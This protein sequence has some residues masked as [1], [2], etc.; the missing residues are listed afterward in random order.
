MKLFAV[1]RALATVV[2]MLGLAASAASAQDEKTVGLTMA[3]PAAVGLHWQ[4]A[5]RFAIRPDVTYGWSSTETSSSF[6]GGTETVYSGGVS[7]VVFGLPAGQ[8]PV[9]YTS[10][11][12]VRTNNVGAGISGIVTVHRNEAL[13]IYLGPRISY[14]KAT[15]TS[16]N[17]DL[18]AGLPPEFRELVGQQ[19]RTTKSSNTSYSAAALFGAQY[20]LSERFALLV[21]TGV[22][23]G[24]SDSGNGTRFSLESRRRS[25]NQRSGIGAI[26]FF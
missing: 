12:S 1:A 6:G 23:Y 13:R 19:S 25:I 16:T 9:P 17:D 18:F 2:A 15:V 21:E 24:W 20:A 11:T 10:T 4:I 5:D 8:R 14:S 22:A 3:Y 26:L 7:Q